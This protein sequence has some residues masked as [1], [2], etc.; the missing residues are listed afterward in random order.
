MKKILLSLGLL[1][2]A[3]SCTT[4]TVGSKQSQ[5]P[6]PTPSERGGVEQPPVYYDGN[7]EP[8]ACG[9]FLYS[10]EQ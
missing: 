5:L 9:L 4:S 1:L 8:V 7:D 6:P 10:E 3:I 2:L